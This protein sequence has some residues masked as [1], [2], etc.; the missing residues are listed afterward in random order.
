M[1]GFLS[2]TDAA[3]KLG[4]SPGDLAREIAEGKVVAVVKNNRSWISPGEVRRLSRAREQAQPPPNDPTPPAPLEPPPQVAPPEVAPPAAETVDPDKLNELQK[5]CEAMSRRLE[6]VENV[7]RRLKLGLEETEATLRRSRNAK[8]NLENDVI[9]LTDQLKKALTRSSALEREVQHLTHEL[10]RAEEKY[11]NDMRR[12][13][14]LD[15]AGPDAGQRSETSPEEMEHLRLQMQE[16]DRI[17]G[18]EYQERAVLRAQLEERSQK[19]FELKARYDKEK[20][21]WSEILARE[22]QTHGILKSQ[23]EELSTRANTKGWNPFR[24]S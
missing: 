8:Q 4:K 7:N 23:L 2:L 20:S 22:L 21:E 24:R 18:Q 15:R 19:Y 9:G 13:R 12:F 1:E 11:A 10:E 5:R 6:E 17:I 14:N 16:K 3:E